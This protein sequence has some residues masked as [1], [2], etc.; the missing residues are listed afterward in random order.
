M[1]QDNYDWNYLDPKSALPT[2]V[3][4]FLISIERT[5]LHI[6]DSHGFKIYIYGVGR[7]NKK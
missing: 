7:L 6:N 2:S 1:D 5:R 3:R 4:D